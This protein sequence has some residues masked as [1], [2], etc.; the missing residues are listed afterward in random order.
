[1]RVLTTP[2]E[3]SENLIRLIRECSSCQ[4]AVAWASAHFDAF[5]RLEENHQKIEKMVVGLHFHQTD[6]DFIEAFMSH[7][8]K[9][10][11]VRNTEGVFHPKVYLFVKAEGEWECLVG[12]PNFTRAGFSSNDEMAVLMTHQ[13][14]GANEALER[15]KASIGGY[16]LEAGSLGGI[17]LCA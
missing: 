17:T 13:D 11:F 1:M 3:I 6:P 10:R 2:A 7:P 5:K 14:Q 8:N 15:I 16:W 9:V 4:A 12:S